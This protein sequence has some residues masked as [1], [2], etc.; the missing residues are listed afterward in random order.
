MSD[1]LLPRTQGLLKSV[2]DRR[3]ERRK[4]K[5]ILGDEAMREFEKMSGLAQGTHER[6]DLNSR[7]KQSGHGKKDVNFGLKKEREATSIWGETKLSDC[8]SS[9]PR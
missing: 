7:L 6:K 3:K 5:W 2:G 8:N 1:L 9:I 4:R